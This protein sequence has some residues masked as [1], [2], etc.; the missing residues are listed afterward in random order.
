MR[1]STSRKNATGALARAVSVQPL[2]SRVHYAGDPFAS[3][4]GDGN[5]TAFDNQGVL[6]RVWREAATGRLLYA[7]RTYNLQWGPSTVIDSRSIGG[8]LSLA[9]DPQNRPAV[10]YHD[11]PSGD[12]VLSRF[13]GTSWTRTIIDANGD[14]GEYSSLAFTPGGKP[15]VSYYDV[16]NGDLRLAWTNASGNWLTTAIETPGNLGA[17]NS[18]VVEP[19]TNLLR[20]AYTDSSGLRLKYAAQQPDGTWF[21]R[22]IDRGT[23]AGARFSSMILDNEGLPWIAYYDVG[24]KDLKVATTPDN[25][26]WSSTRVAAPGNQGEF[27]QLFL[28][29]QSRVSVLYLNRTQNTTNLATYLKGTGWSWTVKA[30]GGSNLSVDVSINGRVDWTLTS[31]ID[32]QLRTSTS[33][34]DYVSSTDP[35]QRIIH[36]ETIGGS[37]GSEARRTVGWP[38]DEIGWSGYV[39]T[40][41]ATLRSYGMERILLHNP[42]G[43]ALATEPYYQFDQYIHAQ[44]AGLTWLTNGFVEAWRP[45]VQSGVEVIA[46]IGKLFGDPD[47]ENITDLNQYMARVRASIQPLLDA[48][49]NIGFDSI[50]GADNTTRAWLVVDMLRNSGVKVYAENRP[51]WAFWWWHN[52]G[53]VYY[54]DGFY[55]SDPEFDPV[56]NSWAAPNSMLRG[57]KIRFLAH[58]PVGTPQGNYN[59]VAPEIIQ[60]IR[61]GD[62]A[63]T[64]FA[65]LHQLGLTPESLFTASRAASSAAGAASSPFAPNK[66]VGDLDDLLD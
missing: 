3:T 22:A 5:D 42:F 43:A 65:V 14:V 7:Q 11:N 49:I 60:I 17:F 24:K 61:E 46:Y 66:L 4:G 18:L 63:A 29:S 51:P 31:N 59:W 55:N 27:A 1:S 28:D 40:R 35:G 53:G 58:A 15:F 64:D 52:V 12:L 26:T 16:T 57:E 62:T 48:G 20:I 23:T 8:N 54:N 44:E 41:I 47:F 39:N 50:V 32:G 13:D 38:I 37:G 2:E 6:H 56:A 21:I 10:A 19:T 45:V 36:W 9:I 25:I 30:L 33:D 34:F